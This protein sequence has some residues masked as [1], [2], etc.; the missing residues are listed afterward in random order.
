MRSI[1]GMQ[2]NMWPNQRAK[3]LATRETVQADE[4]SRRGE[5]GKRGEEGVI[6]EGGKEGPEV[7]VSSCAHA[8]HSTLGSR[9]KGEM[10][11]KE[12]EKKGDPIHKIRATS[13]I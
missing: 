4:E 3:E 7:W 12:E 2:V 8:T 6:S 9:E 1:I 10:G 5:G 13:A 11:P